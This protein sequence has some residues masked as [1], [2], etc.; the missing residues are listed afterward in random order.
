M[1]KMP[2]RLGAALLAV[3]AM[4][5]HAA[6]F[7]AKSR[8]FVIYSDDNQ[9]ALLE[10]AN[11]LER[12]DG[13]ARVALRMDDPDIGDGNRLT[14]FV[15]PTDKDVWA[16]KGDTG[17]FLAGFYV[18]RVEG[19][20][21]FIAKRFDASPDSSRDILFFHEYTHHLM[22]Q[23]LDRPY[24]QWY[25]EGFAEFFSTA[26]FERD[27]SVWFGGA[28]QQRGWGL[29]NGPRT[30]LESLLAGLPE[31]LSLVQGDAFYGRSWLLS[32]YLMMESKRKG[33]LGTY[34]GLLSKG[35]ADPM[36]AQQAFGDFKQLDRELDDYRSKGLLRFKIGAASIATHPIEVTPLSPGAA[37]VI[38]TRA[39]IKYGVD[40]ATAEALAAQLRQVE[41]HYPG[42]NLVE[43][44][45][46]E[47]ELDADHA[48]AA[49]AATK[50]A[51]VADPRDTGS[52]V[53]EGRAIEKMALA[54]DIDQS[55][56]LFDQAR[57]EFVAANKLDT[58][59]PEPLYEFYKSYLH[60]RRR[61]NANAIAALH[62]ASDL[63]PQDVGVRMN[64]A[65]AYLSENKLEEARATLTVVAYSPHAGRAADAARR[66]IADID[67]GNGRLALQES[68]KGPS[69]TPPPK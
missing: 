24:P 4:P 23:A 14:V 32:H 45:L 5:A 41:A 55:P 67:A 33:Q 56:P 21:V 28:D 30:P 54:G 63:A 64:S 19:S 34:I 52:M 12:F 48:E 7:Q 31:K 38:L 53:L 44:T 62:Y 39:K 66:M 57:A 18:G 22:M 10:Y 46:A 1:F 42:D 43:S 27:G 17:T 16:L 60:E 69:Q 13:G 8:H 35:V 9:R 40:P 68:S 11:K 2:I 36:A 50:R 51:L 15:L 58:E 65:I 20:L 61:P 26:Q 29:F 47:A 37:Q 3:A 59:D 6:W 25:V 49:K